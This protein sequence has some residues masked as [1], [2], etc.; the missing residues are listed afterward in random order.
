ML[1]VAVLF[2]VGH[3]YKGPAGVIDSTY[4]GLVLGGAYLLAGRNLWV[5]ILAHGIKD[6]VALLAVFMGWAN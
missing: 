3:Y 5:S 6:T 2:G 1:Y 4:S